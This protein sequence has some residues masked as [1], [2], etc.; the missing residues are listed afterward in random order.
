MGSY[1]LDFFS[2]SDNI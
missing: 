2:V 1:H